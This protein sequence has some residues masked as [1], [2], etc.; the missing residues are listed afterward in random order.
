MSTSATTASPR[1]PHETIERT[2]HLSLPFRRELG[3]AHYRRSEQ[4]WEEAGRPTCIVS[5]EQ[6]GD[7]LIVRVDVPRAERR[8]VPIDAENPWD[9]HP[10]AIHGDGVQHYVA[11][12]DRAGGWL[13]VPI[14]DSARVARRTAD[15]WS[16]SLTVEATWR[17]SADGYELAA[18]VT[19]PPRTEEVDLDVLVNENARGR[20]RRRG[21]LVLSG[22]HDEFVYL[23][24]D[25][26]ERERLLRFALDDR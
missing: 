4:S 19:L 9:N 11:A 17:P 15:G 1:V 26:H 25:H 10:A 23:R 3:A 21:Q 6:S 16:D 22:A 20:T 14:A 12:G 18:S 7:R 5:I 24:A 8:F 13:L 2:R